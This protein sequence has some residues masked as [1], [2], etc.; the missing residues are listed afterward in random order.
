[1][2]RHEFHL[3]LC[4]Y[5]STVT[6]IL[7]L[8]HPFVYIYILLFGKGLFGGGRVF[9]RPFR[10]GGKVQGHKQTLWEGP[11]FDRLY[12]KLKVLLFYC[13]VIDTTLVIQL[14]LL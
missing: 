4:K 8:P 5:F 14:L 12:H 10:H 6:V 2:D 1:M 3:L 7:Y 11:N 13:Y 9:P